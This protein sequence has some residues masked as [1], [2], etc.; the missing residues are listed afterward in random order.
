[1]SEQMIVNQHLDGDSFF[2]RAGPTGILLCHGFTA[3]T[4]EVR[5]LGK[6]LHQHG[7]TVSA[8]LL[9]GHNSHPKELNQVKWQQWVSDIDSCYKELVSQCDTIFVGGESTGALLALHLATNYPQI[10]GVLAYAPALRLNISIYNIVKLFLL[11]PIIPYVPKPN[12]KEN[13]L[14]RGYSVNPLK[15]TIQLLKLQQIMLNRLPMIRQP[16]LIVQGRLDKTVH[17]GVPQIIKRNIRSSLIEIHWMEQSSHTVILDKE[18]KHIAQITLEFIKK[19][20]NSP[21]NKK[22][23][24]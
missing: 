6:F 14:W 12:P 21:I 13:P 15:G 22:G 8:P 7:Y 2:W 3:T 9:T 16:V 5:P 11:S 18:L 10:S 1:M 24:D 19:S 17:P 23:L 4:S 20:T